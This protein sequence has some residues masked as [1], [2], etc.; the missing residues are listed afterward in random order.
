MALQDL[1]FDGGLFFDRRN[2]AMGKD[3]QNVV[4]T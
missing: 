4:Q 1:E 2:D 3:F